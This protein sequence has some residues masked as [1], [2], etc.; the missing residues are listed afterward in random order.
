MEKVINLIAINSGDHS[1]GIQGFEV[2]IMIEMPDMF[3][4]RHYKTIENEFKEFCND[5]FEDCTSCKTFTVEEYEKFEQASEE[6]WI[7]LHNRGRKKGD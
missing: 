6:Y 7:E 5:V 3:D 4:K 2:R 1:V